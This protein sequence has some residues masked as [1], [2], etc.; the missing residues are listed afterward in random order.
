[1]SSQSDRDRPNVV[2]FVIMAIMLAGTGLSLLF[3]KDF[4]LIDGT[5][6]HID[7]I[8][9]CLL[10]KLLGTGGTC[11]GRHAPDPPSYQLVMI[12]GRSLKLGSTTAGRP[13]KMS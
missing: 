1:M 3:D 8:M 13:G 5:K 12:F 7:A 2:L 10:A 4:P 6:V 9:Y 11:K